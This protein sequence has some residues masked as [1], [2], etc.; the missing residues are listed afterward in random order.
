MGNFDTIL[1]RIDQLKTTA[2]QELSGGDPRTYIGRATA[3]AQAQE[4]LPDAIAEYMQGL[5]KVTSALIVLGEPEATKQF[6]TI[7]EQEGQTVNVNGARL[8]EVIAAELSPT[9]DSSGLG[10]TQ[11]SLLDQTVDE[12]GQS[13]EV[14]PP[15]VQFTKTYVV[16]SEQDVVNGVRETLRAQLG[17]V[18]NLLFIEKDAMRIAADKRLNQSVVPVVITGLTKDEADNMAKL[19][20][21][22]TTVINVSGTVTT[23]EVLNAF[24]IVKQKATEKKQ[25]SKKS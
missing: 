6:A 18:M 23:D 10:M 2:N 22:N 4:L 12:I 16:Q 19:F 8:Y 21:G 7:A 14:D 3:K 24:G 11:S 5:R 20:D 15:N 1:N 17:D 9:L 13:L 25:K